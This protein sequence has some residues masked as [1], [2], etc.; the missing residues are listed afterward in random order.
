MRTRSC[1]LHA[2]CSLACRVLALGCEEVVDACERGADHCPSCTRDNLILSSTTGRFACVNAVQ[3]GIRR[4]MHSL[5]KSWALLRA[6]TRSLMNTSGF[7][8]L[9]SDGW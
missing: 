7:E 9:R 8:A 4:A 5:G 6:S 1:A 3:V 2:L